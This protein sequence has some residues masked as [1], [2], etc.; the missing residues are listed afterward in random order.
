MENAQDSRRRL[1]RYL[2][3]IAASCLIG[4][5]F[6]YYL[7]LLGRV[8]MSGIRALE[9][10]ARGGIVGALFWSVEVFL[11]NGPRRQK[12]QTLS[13]GTR[14]AARIVAYVV[15]IELGLF[16]GQALFA[17]HDPFGLLPK[18]PMTH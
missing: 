7:E 11:L 4:V 1:N 6:G 8:G 12:F 14:L 2:R 18:F 5:A 15:L 3:L 10:A 9:F 17:P 16:I 13:Y